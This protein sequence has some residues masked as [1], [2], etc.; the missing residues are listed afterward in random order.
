MTWECLFLLFLKIEVNFHSSFLHEIFSM[1]W[2]THACTPTWKYIEKINYGFFL[3]KSHDFGDWSF[4]LSVNGVSNDYSGRNSVNISE[5]TNEIL[6]IYG[7][8]KHSYS[9]LTHPLFELLKSFFFIGEWSRKEWEKESG[10]LAKL[11]ISL[12]R[13][14]FSQDHSLLY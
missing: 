12:L 2:S 5:H 6:C 4:G 14:Q 10:K 11:A 9:Y 8:C 1:S 13:L 3:R 7:D